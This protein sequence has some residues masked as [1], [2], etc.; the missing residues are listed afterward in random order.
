METLSQKRSV[1]STCFYAVFLNWVIVPH[2]SV[3]PRS[4]SIPPQNDYSTNN[5][6]K[7]HQ[8]SSHMCAFKKKKISHWGFFLEL[9]FSFHFFIFHQL[10]LLS[11][12]CLHSSLSPTLLCAFVTDCAQGCA[13]R[14][15]LR[16]GGGSGGERGGF[17]AGCQ[18][19]GAWCW[20][21]HELRHPGSG[22]Q[23]GGLLICRQLSVGLWGLCDAWGTRY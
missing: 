14:E 23:Q 20:A 1:T 4:L 21:V 7:V 19:A 6:Y 8:H 22:Q 16:W 18:R 2:M 5:H 17:S 15:G 9:T 11:T 13:Q 3:S 10:C 12:L